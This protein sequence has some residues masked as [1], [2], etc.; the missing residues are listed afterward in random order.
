M[1]RLINSD[2]AMVRD[3]RSTLARLFDAGHIDAQ[4]IAR[5]IAL[6]LFQ[7]APELRTWRLQSELAHAPD[8][9]RDGLRLALGLWLTLTGEVGAELEVAA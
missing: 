1:N 4:G 3:W 7:V 6:P 9:Y 5:A 8:H 2:W